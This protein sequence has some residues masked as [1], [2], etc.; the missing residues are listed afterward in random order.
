MRCYRFYGRATDPGRIETLRRVVIGGL[1][2]A[3]VAVAVGLQALNVYLA[4]AVSLQIIGVVP[5]VAFVACSHVRLEPDRLV[6]VKD[7]GFVRSRTE[8]PRGLIEGAEVI[9]EWV[10]KGVASIVRL[11]LKGRGCM[12]LIV[13]DPEGLA[14]ELGRVERET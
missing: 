11:Y 14:N 2:S 13:G 1:V 12:P 6:V 9:E 10:G 3:A 7:Y 5:I 8:I 4:T